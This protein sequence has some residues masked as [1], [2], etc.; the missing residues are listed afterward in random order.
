VDAMKKLA[1]TPIFPLP[2]LETQPRKDEGQML[3]VLFPRFI[4]YRVSLM[5]VIPV[6]VLKIGG[7]K[8]QLLRF[9]D[10]AADGYCIVCRI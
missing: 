4:M 10:I 6:G 2:V 1:P 9:G 5:A 8:V 7:D 3:T